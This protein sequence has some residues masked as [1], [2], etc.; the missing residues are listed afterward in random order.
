MLCHCHSCPTRSRLTDHLAATPFSVGPVRTAHHKW[1]AC[2]PTPRKGGA[3]TRYPNQKRAS[4]TLYHSRPN[5]Q[6]R[7]PSVSSRGLPKAFYPLDPKTTKG[8]SKIGNP[9]ETQPPIL[10]PVPLGRFPPLPLSS[11]SIVYADITCHFF[12]SLVPFVGPRR[13]IW[14]PASRHPSKP[15][16]AQNLTLIRFSKT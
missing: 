3:W 16:P 11:I 15:S 10:K 14:D 13:N 4:E 8:E 9:Y 6:A 2:L 5:V 12:Y 1:I 7:R